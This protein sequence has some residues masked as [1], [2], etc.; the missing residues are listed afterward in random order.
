[1]PAVEKQS[2]RLNPWEGALA[3]IRSKLT[4]LHI[5]SNKWILPDQSLGSLPNLHST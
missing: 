3:V 5:R 2:H 4:P 1:M